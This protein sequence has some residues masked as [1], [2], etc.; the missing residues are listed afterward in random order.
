MSILP[1]FW[2]DTVDTLTIATS[3]L[4]TPREYGIDFDTGRLTGEIVEGKEAI[5]V[6]IWNCLQTERY[7]YALYTWQYGVEYEQYIG[8]AVT[9]DFLTAD[10]QIETEEALMV[11]P[12]ITGISDFEISF[13]G[14]KIHISFTAE[15]TLG[16]LEV[17]T[18]V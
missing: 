4:P 15:T 11:S 3:A 17:N 5:K 8:Q 7:R 16:S 1:T 12:Y 18:N 10:A 6:W 2:E 14:S 9:E 13:S